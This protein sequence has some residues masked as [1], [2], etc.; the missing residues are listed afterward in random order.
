MA[1]PVASFQGGLLI[2][3][4]D[5][6]REAWRLFAQRLELAREIGIE[7]LVISEEI[8]GRVSSQDIER[9][10]MSLRQ[11]AEQA[12]A[13]DVRLALEFQARSV[14]C[15]NLR[16][17]VALVQEINSPHLGICLDAFHFEVGPSKE[18]DLEL[19][20]PENL[21]HVQL[22]DLA[23]TLREFAADRDRILPGEGDIALAPIV[24]RLISIGYSRHVAVELMNPR[25]FQVPPRSFGEIAMTSLRLVLGQAK[26]E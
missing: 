8:H 11:A 10:R 25:L 15:N 6:R 16:T 19:L 23:D 5:A 24:E 21:F 12:A 22:C 3:Q 4:G 7:T 2:S 17:A 13:L 14:F 20:S 1:A 26:M 18:A 9:F